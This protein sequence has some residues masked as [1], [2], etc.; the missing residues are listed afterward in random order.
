M[1]MGAYDASY[2]HTPDGEE[3]AALVSLNGPAKPYSCNQ[4]RTFGLQPTAAIHVL[5]VQVI[6]GVIVRG[7]G[8]ERQAAAGIEQSID[9]VE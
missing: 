7:G 2:S 9:A 3:I 6:R 8:S 4:T 1:R 5:F